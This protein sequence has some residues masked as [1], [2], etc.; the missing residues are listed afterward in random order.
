MIPLNTG[1]HA[2]V[3]VR[4]RPTTQ[5]ALNNAA[6]RTAAL[7]ICIQQIGLP[8]PPTLPAEKLVYV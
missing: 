6:R 1:M 4:V 8:K 2:C 7:A 5:V 3:P